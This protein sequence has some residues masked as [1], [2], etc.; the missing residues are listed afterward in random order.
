MYGTLK[1]MRGIIIVSLR[2]EAKYLP[3]RH[4]GGEHWR[5]GWRPI[6]FSVVLRVLVGGCT[7]L[8]LQHNFGPAGARGEEHGATQNNIEGVTV[9]LLTERRLARRDCLRRERHTM[10]L[11][12]NNYIQVVHL[13]GGKRAACTCTPK[14]RQH[15]C[16][17]KSDSSPFINACLHAWGKE[18]WNCTLH[19]EMRSLWGLVRPVEPRQSSN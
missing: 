13:R 14:Y 11:C 12:A 2:V 4:W 17:C 7:A 9:V 10:T 3:G 16:R 8:E 6:F 1:A 5:V 18:I 15:C 19:G